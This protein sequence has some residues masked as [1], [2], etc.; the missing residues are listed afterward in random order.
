MGQGG[1]ILAAVRREGRKLVSQRGRAVVEAV[2]RLGV[3][4][5]FDSFV[6]GQFFHDLHGSQIGTATCSHGKFAASK[7]A[8]VLHHPGIRG[9]GAVTRFMKNAAR[10][11][12]RGDL[13]FWELTLTTA[14]LLRIPLGGMV[15]LLGTVSHSSFVVKVVF[16][17]PGAVVALR[18]F[19]SPVLQFSVSLWHLSVQKMFVTIF[20]TTPNS[21]AQRMTNCEGI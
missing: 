10:S 17:S 4:G 6:H 2:R 18:K 7:D 13:C 11:R 5:G 15:L 8:H 21:P 12:L 16:L 3:V 14:S 1:A 9:N 19:S 20:S